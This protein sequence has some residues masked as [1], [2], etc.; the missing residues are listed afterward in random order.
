MLDLLPDPHINDILRPSL[1]R[2]YMEMRKAQKEQLQEEQKQAKQPKKKQVRY[3][4]YDPQKICRN[5]KGIFDSRKHQMY[6][7]PTGS[8]KC[9]TFLCEPCYK[10][11]KSSRKAVY[12]KYY[13][14][15]E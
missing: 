8:R 1:R 11:P 14:R 10:N 9:R 6:F 7:T 3:S 4:K 15:S 2:L 13:H 12:E 5:C